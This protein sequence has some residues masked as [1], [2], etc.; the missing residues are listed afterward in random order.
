[1][2][3]QPRQ[4][5]LVSPERL[6]IEWSDGQVREYTVRE[7][8][9]NCPCAT[10]LEKRR[11]PPA[12]PLSLPILKAEETRPLRIAQMEPQGRYAY[13]IHFSDGH[14]TGIYTLEA[15]REL[16]AVVEHSG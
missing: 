6:H 12:A 9:E 16:G 2:T 11:A 5:K 14:N 3:L 8:R 13:G 15:L 7:L 1:M 10:C 4:M